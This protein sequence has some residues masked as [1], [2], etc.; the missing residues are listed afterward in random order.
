MAKHVFSARIPVEIEYPPPMEPAVRKVLA[1]EYDAPLDGSGLTILDI[2]ANV[3]SFTLWASL[4][5]PGSAVH[6]YEPEPATHELLL[7][8]VGHL[9]D[10]TCTR[11][12][13]YPSDDATVTFFSRYPGDGEAGIVELTT[14][15]APSAD[16][17]FEVPVVRPETLPRADIVKVDAEG[18]EAAILGGLDLGAVSLVMVE[19]QTNADREAIKALTREHFVVEHE[20]ATPWDSL[21]GRYGYRADM[22]GET[23]GVMVF[24]NRTSDRLTRVST[25]RAPEEAPPPSLRKA[26]RPLPGLVAAAARRRLKGDEPA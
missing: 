24:A 11:A 7:R 25:P 18:A 26:L 23:Q 19:F 9:P 2:G 20:D 14:F 22:A 3:G 5:W 13:V 12:A 21:A 16:R 6:A 8:N 15:E 1:G 10:V 17:T 4:R